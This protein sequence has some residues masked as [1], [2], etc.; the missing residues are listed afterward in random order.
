MKKLFAFIVAFFTTGLLTAQIS[1]TADSIDILIQQKTDSVFSQNKLP[2]LF[3][4]VIN[5]GKHNYYAKG[6]AN[7]DTKMPF[8]SATF[9]EIGSITKTFT[10]F[11]LQKIL[12]EYKISDTSSILPYL[13]DSV[14]KNKVLETISFLQLL[15]HTSGLPRLPDNMQV[16]LEQKSPYDNY[17]ADKLFTYLKACNPKPDGKSNYSNLGM[18]LAG[19]LAELISGKKYSTLLEEY[20][21][22][23]FKMLSNTEVFS[24]QD[25]KSLG[26]FN[27]EKTPY[28]NMD[29]LAPAG[30][31]K[32]NGREM[33]TYLNYMANTTDGKNKKIIDNLL[34]PTIALNQKINVCKAWHTIEQKDKPR[35]Y[36]HNGGTFGFSTFAAFVKDEQKA[37]LVVINKFSE[38]KVADGL[39]VAIM[40]LLNK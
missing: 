28:W 25:N 35:I 20:I 36:W 19:V 15:N 37:V 22:R 31:I 10:A 6:F 18:G 3:V 11:V 7:P 14:Q 34:Q 24:K 32:S 40:K 1:N 12:E 39:G 9:F 8:D 2:G 17:G 27:D 23:P 30:G 21:F 4:A 16:S 26:F 29:V 38:N 13:P 33:L 5:N